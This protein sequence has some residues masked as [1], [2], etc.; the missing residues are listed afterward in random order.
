M[1]EV[2]A[3]QAALEGLVPYDPKYLP[4]DVLLSANENPES[5]PAPVLAQIADGL[6]E[7]AC[8]R[9][10]DPLANGLRDDI[11]KLWGLER[12][13][14]LVGNAGDE[15]LFNVA[16][17]WGGPGRTLLTLPPTFSVYE[18]NAR[19]TGTNV[20]RI[21]RTSAAG[22]AEARQAQ[23]TAGVGESKCAT[24]VG[25]AQGATRDGEAPV[26]SLEEEPFAVDEQAV[27][28]RVSQGDV[29][30]V[31]LT[32]PNNPTGNATPLDFTERLLDAS[33]ALVLVDEAYQEFGGATAVPLIGQ[34]KN[35]VVLR[36]FSKAYS[37]A[38]LRLGYVLA[39]P[40]VIRELI[41]VRQPYSVDAFSQL[42]G[43][44]ILAHRP[45][46]DQRVRTIVSERDRVYGALRQI[47]GVTPY[48]S[49][50]NFLLAQLTATSASPEEAPV[51]STVAVGGEASSGSA[52]LD[53]AAAAKAASV[54]QALYD[55]G[56][57]VR[58]FSHAP[59]LTGCLRVSIGTAR[60][61]D[62]FLEVLR[63]ALQ[64]A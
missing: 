23:R 17:A 57:L 20:E 41:K 49:D 40:D 16:L 46:F 62:R 64:Q 10:P 44:A 33:D 39:Q 36:T 53:D 61:N 27:L 8:N 21:P 56:V 31:V 25:K 50:A 35:L 34:H 37:A 12:E 13:C 11:A 29:D 5:L 15:L 55:Q 59:G 2:R 3:P 63:Q 51:R 52:A 43:R 30:Y 47:E 26:A 7:L 48:P 9:Y 19:L 6:S 14:V 24:G 18:A 22:L 28:D 45:L 38:G 54:W 32:S 42:V 58:D 4:A 60:E 1:K